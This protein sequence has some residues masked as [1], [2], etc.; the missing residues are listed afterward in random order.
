MLETIFKWVGIIFLGALA[1]IGLLKV[2]GGDLSDLGSNPITR[3][4]P[5]RLIGRNSVSCAA[6]CYGRP[7]GTRIRVYCPPGY[8]GRICTCVCRRY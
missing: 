6:V 1:I 7:V 4:Y 2:L 5:G 3:P 8:P